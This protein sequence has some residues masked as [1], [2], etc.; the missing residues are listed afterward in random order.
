MPTGG[1]LI[2]HGSLRRFFQES[3]DDA[4]RNQRVEA[5]DHTVVYLV[6]LLV[7]FSRADNLFVSTPEG[8]QLRPLALYYSDAVNARGDRERYQA[9][10]SLGDVALFLA[11]LFAERFAH[12]VVDIEYCVAMGGNAYRHLADS[13]S[14]VLPAAVFGDIYSELADNF[15][16]FADVLSEVADQGQVENAIDLLRLY[17]VWTKTGSRRVGDRLRRFGI[18]PLVDVSDHK[19]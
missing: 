12:R 15:I 13:M 5:D 16:C 19:H 7:F 4:L 18:S 1:S 3:V 14:D 11:G 10:R 17:E 6:N 9:L 8:R 2:E